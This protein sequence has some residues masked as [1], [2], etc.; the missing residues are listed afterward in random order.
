M[1]RKVM[2]RVDRRVE[3]PPNKIPDMEGTES[4][5]MEVSGEH[6]QILKDSVMTPLQRAKRG[7][8]APEGE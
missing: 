7:L 2:Q 6:L 3:N 8:P 1:A 5:S 4:P